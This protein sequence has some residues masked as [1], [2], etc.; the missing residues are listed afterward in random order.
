MRIVWPSEICISAVG[1]V[2]PPLMNLN[3]VLDERGQ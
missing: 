3:D 1:L 2:P